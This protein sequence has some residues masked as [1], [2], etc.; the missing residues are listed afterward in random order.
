MW[1]PFI[2]QYL[3]QASPAKIY[4]LSSDALF[5]LDGGVPSICSFDNICVYL[6]IYLFSIYIYL[7][8]A[9][10]FAFSFLFEFYLSSGRNATLS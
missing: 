2:L 9:S 4:I 10:I 8:S 7:L 3:V 5:P 1:Y 6:S